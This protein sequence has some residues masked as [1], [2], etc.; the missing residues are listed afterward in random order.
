MCNA[1]TTTLYGQPKASGRNK[2]KLV[3]PAATICL[4]RKQN[5]TRPLNNHHNFAVR[6]TQQKIKLELASYFQQQIVVVKQNRE[7]CCVDV[8]KSVGLRK[9]CV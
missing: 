7:Y 1:T 4:T 8:R 5:L 2:F 3:F 6:Q 9:I